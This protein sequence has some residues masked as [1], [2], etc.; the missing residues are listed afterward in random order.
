MV[1]VR[2]PR[3]GGA[4]GFAAGLVPY[5][6]DNSGPLFEWLASEPSPELHED[7]ADVL[8]SEPLFFPA[9]EDGPADWLMVGEV[10]GRPTPVVVPLAKAERVEQCRPIGIYEAT[11]ELLRAYMK[12]K[13][14]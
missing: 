6:L 9:R 11:G 5:Q 7:L 1:L 8:A 12:E 3:F 14:R 10:P 13:R 2:L 4:T